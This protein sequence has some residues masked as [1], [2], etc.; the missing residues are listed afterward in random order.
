M[1]WLLL[2]ENDGLQLP[3]GLIGVLVFVLAFP[4]SGFVKW[5]NAIKF[6]LLNIQAGTEEE[7]LKKLYRFKLL[8]GIFFR[9]R[10]R[11]KANN[12]TGT[13]VA[14]SSNPDPVLS[15]VIAKPVFFAQCAFYFFGIL[16]IIL[17]ALYEFSGDFAYKIIMIVYMVLYAV[18]YCAVM[19]VAVSKERAAVEAWEHI[20]PSGNKK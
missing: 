11:T 1:I 9:G 2:A 3:L 15:G 10:K 20:K 6:E 8:G 14:T 4:F 17:S 19:F 18:G 7:K 16:G 13:L 5:D 12:T